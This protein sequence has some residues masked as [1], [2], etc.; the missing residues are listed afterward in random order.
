ME[1]IFDGNALLHVITHQAISIFD[2]SYPE[3]LSA[4][5]DDNTPLSDFLKNEY[6]HTFFNYVNSSIRP[7]YSIITHLHFVLDDLSWRKEYVNKFFENNPDHN[8]FVYKGKRKPHKYVHVLNKFFKY[9]HEELIDVLKEIPGIFIYST[10]GA[11]GDDIIA[12]LVDRFPNADIGIWTGDYDIGQLAID[13]HRKV[14]ILGPKHI[15][16]KR[17]RV[18]VNEHSSGM[19]FN[20]N[21]QLHEAIDLLLRNQTYEKINLNPGKD[22]LIKLVTRD[23]SDNI[24]SIYVRYNKN[25]SPINITPERGVKF[26]A[27]IFEKYNTNELLKMMDDLDDVLFDEVMECIRVEFKISTE[28]KEM[29]D[30]LVDKIKKN[31]ER[32][33]KLIRLS[34]HHIPEMLFVMIKRV[35][36]FHYKEIQFDYA[37]FAANINERKRI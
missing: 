24:G 7:F 16:T 15:G 23:T 35:V 13:S 14:F 8:P 19:S 5:N 36:D 27:P 33:I 21:I 11:E 29:Y 37:A 28:P 30:S 20:Y 10:I 17:R 25:N 18:S 12:Y 31:Y 34:K 26:L 2:K 9:F 3:E 6:K 22:I 32:N 4:V 1:F